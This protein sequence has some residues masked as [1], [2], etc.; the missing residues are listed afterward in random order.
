MIQDLLSKNNTIKNSNKRFFSF[1]KGS[2]FRQILKYLRYLIIAAL[3][4]I[5]VYG[6][7]QQFLDPNVRT[8]PSPGAGFEIVGKNETDGFNTHVVI[9][10]NYEIDYNKVV[11]FASAWRLGPFY[12]LFV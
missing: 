3:L 10:G 6:C 2:I 1:F 11:T 12:G 7:A 8:Y 9:N 5:A 4:A